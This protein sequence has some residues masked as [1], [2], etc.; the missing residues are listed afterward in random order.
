MGNNKRRRRFNCEINVRNLLHLFALVILCN[1]IISASDDDSGMERNDSNPVS[2]PGMG[3]RRG[4]FCRHPR[5]VAAPVAD[6]TDELGREDS[7][8]IPDEYN[9]SED[10]PIRYLVSLF[11]VGLIDQEALIRD[12]GLITAAFQAVLESSAPEISTLLPDLANL[13]DD[14]LEC[15]A[16]VNSWYSY[17]LS[18]KFS[19]KRKFMARNALQT[20]ALLNGDRTVDRHAI[21]SVESY[22]NFSYLSLP[23]AKQLFVFAC[24]L[25]GVIDPSKFV[26][27]YL[28]E[29][30]ADPLKW[31]AWKKPFERY[32][33]GILGHDELGLALAA[34][35]ANGSKFVN[36]I[37][38]FLKFGE[39]LPCPAANSADLRVMSNLFKA[40]INNSLERIDSITE[41]LFMAR[42]GHNVEL[43]NPDK[44][45]RPAC[46]EG[47]YL[48]LIRETSAVLSGVFMFDSVALDGCG[49]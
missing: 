25:A 49:L 2:E 38:E 8:L 34:D 11:E 4:A 20:L 32:F 12:K 24:K 5:P 1:S 28:A 23:N 29:N 7:E 26:V 9:D 19:E 27:T 10:D 41:A 14:F 39:T 3:Q 48:N 31:Q 33:P 42:R 30:F 16:Q 46:A 17:V 43:F 18:G 45:N 44:I 35:E 36:A 47:L 21:S 37:A 6:S 40:Y 15:F 22:S 13:E